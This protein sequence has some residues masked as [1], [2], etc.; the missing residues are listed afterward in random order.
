[1]T[2]DNLPVILD[3]ITLK[4]ME[5]FVPGGALPIVSRIREEVTK[6]LFDVTTYS[7]RERIASVAYSIGK[8]KNFLDKMGKDL[9][10]DWQKK[11]KV[12]NAERKIAWDELEA[13]QKEVRQPLTDFE[14]AEK[15]RVENLNSLIARASEDGN[16]CV[17]GWMEF[18]QNGMETTLSALQTQLSETDWKEFKAKATDVY[19]DAIAK[20]MTAIASKVKYE[21]EQAELAEL[22]RKQAEQERIDRETKIAEE[23]AKKAKEAAELEAKAAAQAA[24]DR[25][26]QEKQAEIE[27]AEKAERQAAEAVERERKLIAEKAEKQRV[28]DEARA[29]NK[30]HKAKINNEALKALVEIMAFPDCEAKEIIIAIAEGKIPHVTINY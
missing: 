24:A 30:S 19:T 8:A 4:P 17:I 20:I 25:A 11:T 16:L 18:N 29:A 21:S 14:E 9:T 6:E 27:R 7:G 28:I 10:E 3:V 15:K 13:L 23:A 26:A 1:M 22:R 2:T 5:V 12:V